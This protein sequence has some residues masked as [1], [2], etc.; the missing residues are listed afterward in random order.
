MPRSAR[1][2]APGVLNH[3]IIRGI[4]RREI[5][6]DNEDKDN[7]L[8]RLEALLPETQTTCYA[9][10]A[11]SKSVQINFFPGGCRSQRGG[12]VHPSEPRVELVA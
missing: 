6:R 3:V 5:F 10:A 2:D 1:L 11:F 9:W 4:E 8:D 7:F 12:E